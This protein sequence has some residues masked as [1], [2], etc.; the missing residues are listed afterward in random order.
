MPEIDL[1]HVKCPED[2]PAYPLWRAG[3][4]NPQKWADAFRSYGNMRPLA[5]WMLYAMACAYDEGV[6]DSK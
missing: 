6:S 1:Y 4:R 3:E 5:E 2:H